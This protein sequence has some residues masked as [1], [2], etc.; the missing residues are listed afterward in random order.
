MSSNVV[1]FVTNAAVK[2]SVSASRS[3]SHDLQNGFGV[4]SPWRGILLVEPDVTRLAAE[5]LILTRSNYCVTPAFSQ[6]EIF[7]LRDTKAIALAILSDCLGSRLLAAVAKTVRMQWP[8]AR[9]LILG[10]PESVLED[11][12]YDEQ[13]DR[14]LDPKQLLEDIERLYKDSWNQRSHTLDWN[15]CLGT[16]AARPPVRESDPTKAPPLVSTLAKDLR[17][18]PSGIMSQQR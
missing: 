11:H 14:S 7:I 4:S 10:R 12:L 3:L 17:G 16:C 6:M 9:I 2:S 18:M 1:R 15:V 13:I 5:A 8:R